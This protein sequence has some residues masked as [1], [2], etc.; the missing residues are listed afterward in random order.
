[1]KID[2]SRTA[3]YVAKL[4]DTG[5][6]PHVR[7]M[8]RQFWQRAG[9]CGMTRAEAHF[10]HSNFTFPLQ[11]LRLDDLV[12]RHLEEIGPCISAQLWNLLPHGAER[13]TRL[14]ADLR[15]RSGLAAL[16]TA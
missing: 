3:D 13:P 8:D 4:Q 15:R 6:A 1:M 5:F 16:A 14:L 10:A 12:D 11:A 2:K 9:L 7:G